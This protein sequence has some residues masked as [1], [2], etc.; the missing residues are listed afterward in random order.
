[1]AT[2]PED[3]LNKNEIRK[4]AG[5]KAE[6]DSEY[7]LVVSWPNTEALTKWLKDRSLP[8]DTRHIGVDQFES[9]LRAA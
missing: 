8:L 5:D 1:M 6:N 2:K 7:Y 9:C 4:G 3:K